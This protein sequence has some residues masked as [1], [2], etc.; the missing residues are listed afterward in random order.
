MFPIKF[1]HRLSHN[2]NRTNLPPLPTQCQCQVME[3][4][5][6]HFAL[7]VDSSSCSLIYS[8]SLVS[9]QSVSISDV[10]LLRGQVHEKRRD[11]GWNHI[12]CWKARGKGNRGQGYQYSIHEQEQET[13][14]VCSHIGRE[15]V[16]IPLTWS[17]DIISH[18]GI[19]WETDTKSLFFF[20]AK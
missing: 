14:F 4:K 9:P 19:S 8:V 11:R 3:G 1:F 15:N 7:F 20:F 16:L 17:R 10:S 5:C 6:K 18:E 13:G 2:K 12:K